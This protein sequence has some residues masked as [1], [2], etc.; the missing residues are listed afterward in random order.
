M[1]AC[2]T[3]MCIV[4][5]LLNILWVAIPFTALPVFADTST[6]SHSWS[7][8][9]GDSNIQYEPYVTTNATGDIVVAVHYLGTVDFGG[10]P[11][12]SAGG[13]DIAIAKFDDNGSHIWSERFGD[14]GWGFAGQKI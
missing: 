6:L 5:V 4:L 11:L 10:G 2:S 7:Q 3:G 1:S 12:T 14:I 9:F 13:R 8:R